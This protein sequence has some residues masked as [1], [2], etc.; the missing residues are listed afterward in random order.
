MSLLAATPFIAYQ[1]APTP[2]IAGKP[3]PEIVPAHEDFPAARHA[4]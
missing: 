4:S 1:Q 3:A 2:Q